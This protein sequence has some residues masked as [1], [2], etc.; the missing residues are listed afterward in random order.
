MTTM[1]ESD[2]RTIH[3][4][5]QAL[6]GQCD[7]AMQRD[8]LGFAASDVNWGHRY[9][10][11]PFEEITDEEFCAMVNPL[12]IYR[13]QLLAHGIDTHAL[14][15]IEADRKVLRKNKAPKRR[16]SFAS[17]GTMTLVFPAGLPE[18]RQQI[19]DAAGRGGYRW[20][21]EE[22][23][24]T[25]SRER[26]ASVLPIL[27]GNEFQIDD[28][29]ADLPEAKVPTEPSAPVRTIT[30]SGGKFTI[31]FEYDPNIVTAVRAL[32]GRK[33]DG[34]T[35][36]WT[37]P[38][39]APAAAAIPPFAEA[40]GFD[41]SPEALRS[42]R[43]IL[44]AA[45]ENLDGSRAL[46]ADIEIPGLKATLMPFQKAGVAYALR[47]KRVIIGDQ[48]GLGKTIQAIATMEAADAFPAVVFCPASLTLNW[49]REIRRFVPH[50]SVFVASGLNPTELP[51]ADVIVCSYSILAPQKRAGRTMPGWG[52]A[53]AHVAPRT[54]VL[55]ES[56]FIKNPKAK[57]TEAVPAIAEGAEYVLAMTGT[58]ILNRPK[59]LIT[60]LSI[61]GRLDDL[62]G[63]FK[64]A[65]RYCRA[66]K[67]NFGWDLNGADNLDELSEKLRASCLVRRMKSDVYPELPAKMRS[68]VPIE[69]DNVKLYRSVEADVISYVEQCAQED[70]DFLASIAHLPPQA[71]AQEKA[72]RASSAA[73]SAQRA[74]HLVRLG[75][76]K[77][78]AAKG[79]LKGAIA[80]ISDFVSNEEKL[81]L[82]ADHKA[83]QA[84]LFEAMAD[85]GKKQ[86][87]RVVRYSAEQNVHEQQAAVDAFQNDDNVR[88][89]VVSFKAGQAGWTGTAAS[90]VA[91]L[92]LGWTPGEHEQAEDRCYGRVNDPHGAN[93]WYLLA[94]GTIDE[95]TWDMIEAKRAVADGATAN[96][97]DDVLKRLAQRRAA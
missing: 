6:A 25:I 16:A 51:Q 11:T 53:L 28:I 81:I 13:S 75:K 26:A 14:P 30:M 56:H 29:P 34:A 95:D 71:Q 97:V 48:M 63:W 65:S 45:A 33:F 57:R 24:W 73:M 64:F 76:L 83:I 62:G 69:I 19:K 79:K 32:P 46:D 60:P 72:Q 42:C 2:K 68:V 47:N 3:R 8:N 70:A 39:N 61:L 43:V 77:E 41:L 38:V 93:C 12:R 86:D 31:R 91:F 85:L 59:E 10:A 36:T 87:F 44:D 67:T 1:Q 84:S 17:D 96:V 88:V 82:F 7:G 20:N 18:L 90:N 92:E 89:I 35:K 23:S 37:V 5:V 78:V 49:E 58:P 50:R 80:W 27:Q 94:P 52:D 54:V 74:E 40:H 21:P 4:A 9:A 66:H 22:K 15:V 55:D